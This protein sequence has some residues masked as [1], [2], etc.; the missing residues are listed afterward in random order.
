L[1]RYI[2]DFE[3]LDEEYLVGGEMMTYRQET[4]RVY[5]QERC[6]MDNRDMPDTWAYGQKWWDKIPVRLQNLHRM[7]HG[8]WRFE[9]PKR[10]IWSWAE[11]R[12]QWAQ[13]DLMEVHASMPP[14]LDREVRKTKASPSYAVPDIPLEDMTE[15]QVQRL[16]AR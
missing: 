2:Q 10:S 15:E 6:G 14:E 7:R 4:L 12:G 16:M 5:D 9:K 8:T 3:S 1:T 11:T 13:P